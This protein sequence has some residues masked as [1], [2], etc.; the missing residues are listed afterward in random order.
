[1]TPE[2]LILILGSLFAGVTGLVTAISTSRTSAT[3]SQVEILN[4]TL[5]M[6]QAENRRLCERLEHLEQE[7]DERDAELSALKEWAELLVDQVKRLGDHPVPM[8]ER[9]TKPRRQE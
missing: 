8:P 6:L 1:M 4:N 7:I 9:K 3:K 2:A 5:T